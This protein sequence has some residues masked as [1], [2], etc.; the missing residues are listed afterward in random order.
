MPTWS[1]MCYCDHMVIITHAYRSLCK[2]AEKAG[3]SIKLGQGPEGWTV[4]V[5]LRPTP[6]DPAHRAAGAIFPNIGELDAQSVH[7]L[8]WLRTCRRDAA[9]EVR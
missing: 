5:I 2:S 4:Q 9:E 3:G 6:D 8:G 7:L 1:W